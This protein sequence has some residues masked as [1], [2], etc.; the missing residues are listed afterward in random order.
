MNE[1]KT[2]VNYFFFQAEDGIRDYK[3]TGVQTCALPILHGMAQSQTFASR[4]EFIREFH[5]NLRMLRKN[6]ARRS[7][8]SELRRSEERR[9]GKKN[10]SR[11][12]SDEIKK[13]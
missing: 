3:V 12:P 6:H 5:C 13:K 1:I 4:R 11:R 10:R 9:V 2:M 7:F 8:R